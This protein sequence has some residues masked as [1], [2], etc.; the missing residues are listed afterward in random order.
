VDDHPAVRALTRRTT[1]FAARGVV[2]VRL[3]RVRVRRRVLPW[4]DARAS[5]GDEA[6]EPVRVPTGESGGAHLA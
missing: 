4:R 6:E 1:V 3:L 5:S 2:T